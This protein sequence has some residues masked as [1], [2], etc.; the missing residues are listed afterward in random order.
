MK[1]LPFHLLDAEGP[2]STFLSAFFPLLQFKAKEKQHQ[3]QNA[4]KDWQ[5]LSMEVAPMEQSERCS[6]IC[7]AMVHKGGRRHPEMCC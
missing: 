4:M 3:C 6:S 5:Q 1:S 7:S 2:K